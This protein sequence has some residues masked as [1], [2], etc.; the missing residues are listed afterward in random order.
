MPRNQRK[1]LFLFI[2]FIFLLP[3]IIAYLAVLFSLIWSCFLGVVNLF[4]LYAISGIAA[5]SPAIAAKLMIHKDKSF[6]SSFEDKFKIKNKMSA[7]ALPF[8]IACVTIILT[9]TIACF[10]PEIDFKVRSLPPFMCTIILCSLIADEI[11]WRGY[12]HPLLFQHMKRQYLVPFVVGTIWFMW[13]YYYFCS[14]GL[15]DYINVRFIWF[16]IICIVE[17]YICSSLLK[18]SDNN[19]FSI[20]MYRFSYNLFCYLFN[21]QIVFI[22]DDSAPRIYSILVALEIVSCIVLAFV[23][24]K[25]KK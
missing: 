10:L 11:G 19:L 16:Y 12:L 8:A 13:Y 3:K 22:R 21:I 2:C 1:N 23:V 25:K 18:L 9:K 14:F 17:S 24:R 6:E 20:V 4:I 15:F 7:L 5:A